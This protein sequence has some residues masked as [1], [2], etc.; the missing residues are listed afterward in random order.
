MPDPRQGRASTGGYS[1]R[2]GN[3]DPRLRANQAGSVSDNDLGAGLER[4]DQ[5]RTRVS[6]FDGIPQ[7]PSTASLSNVIAAVNAMLAR[8]KAR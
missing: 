6:A 1:P 5:G 2:L 4:D 3:R 8:A 7:L